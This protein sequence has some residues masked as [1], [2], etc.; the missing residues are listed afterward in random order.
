MKKSKNFDPFTYDGQ[1]SCCMVWSSKDGKKLAT[2]E[3]GFFNCFYKKGDRYE[4]YRKWL[5][6]EEGKGAA[7]VEAWFAEMNN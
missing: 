3:H 1:E 4:F 7:T 2:F 6:D 5:C